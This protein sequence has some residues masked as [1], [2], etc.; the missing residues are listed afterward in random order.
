M[1]SPAVRCRGLVKRYDQLVAV[2]RLDLEVG[3]GECFGLLGPN[4]AGKTTTIE[5]LEGLTPADAGEVWVLGRPWGRGGGSDR[6]L[7][8]RLG[9]QLQEAKF[10]E[11]LTVVE[12]VELFRSFYQRGPDPEDVIRA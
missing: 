2:D 9:I 12:T 11:K 4:G 6:A 1:G 10:Q 8:E 5:I 7:R 3:A